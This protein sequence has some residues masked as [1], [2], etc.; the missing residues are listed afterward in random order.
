[1]PN[2][3]RI[4]QVPHLTIKVGSTAHKVRLECHQVVMDWRTLLCECTQGIQT[5]TSRGLTRGRTDGRTD[6]FI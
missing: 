6:T 1:M 4:F 2:N 5:Q 3:A